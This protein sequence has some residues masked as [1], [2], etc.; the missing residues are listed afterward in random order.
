MLSPA[1]HRRWQVGIMK[2][3]LIWR[4]AA[5]DWRSGELVLLVAALVIAVGTVTAISLFVDR[6]HHALLDESTHMLAADRYI[7]SSEPLPP[8][9]GTQARERGGGALTKRALLQ[10]AHAKFHGRRIQVHAK[11]IGREMVQTMRI[12]AGNV[13]GNFKSRVAQ[14]G[15]QSVVARVASP[16]EDAVDSLAHKGVEIVR[17]ESALSLIFFYEIFCAG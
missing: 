6:L 1:G 15:V 3:L 13:R 14:F 4:M 9:F 7:S 16:F 8:D 5:R 2:P 12:K 11:S 10:L 17:I